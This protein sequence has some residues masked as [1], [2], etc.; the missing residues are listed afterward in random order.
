MSLAAKSSMA[1]P[2]PSLSALPKKPLGGPANTGERQVAPELAV[3]GQ[4]VE[5]V[6]GGDEGGGHH[7]LFRFCHEVCRQSHMLLSVRLRF[8]LVSGLPLGGQP[9]HFPLQIWRGASQ[10]RPL[11]RR[12]PPKT[13]PPPRLH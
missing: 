4:G 10:S 5:L 2:T 6:V 8:L 11:S 12:Q 3:P 9:A 13:V 7:T 1:L